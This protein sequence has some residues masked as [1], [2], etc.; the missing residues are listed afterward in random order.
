MS[1]LTKQVSDYR[2][3]NETQT[4][5]PKSYSLAL[6]QQQFP[7]KQQAILFSSTDGTK[8]EE[9]IFALGSLI[10]AK[11]ILFSSR[12]SNNRICIYLSS[13][14]AV[15]K[16][17]SEY[18]TITINEETLS[19]RR[20]ITP[21]ER[22]IL[23]NVCPTIPH[24]NIENELRKL[25]LNLVS[26][27]SFRKIGVTNPE[28]SH[29]LSFRR[30][31][32]ISPPTDMEI[33]ESL[34]IS[35]DDTSYR[36]FLSLDGLGC[37]KCKSHGHI[38]AHC[39]TN[40]TNS[41]QQNILSSQLI[42]SHQ[43]EMETPSIEPTLTKAATVTNDHQLEPIL[44]TLKRQFT[45]ILTP[46]EIPQNEKQYYFAKPADRSLKKSKQQNALD[47][48]ALAIS[49]TQLLSP[50]KKFIESQ[51][52]VLNFEQLSDFLFNTHGV[53]EPVDIALSYTPDLLGL[54]SMLEKVYPHLE[55]RGFKSKFTKVR[56]KLLNHLQIQTSEYD[57]DSSTDL[58]QV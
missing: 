31:I 12:I 16:F 14:N 4:T 47:K 38:A 7:S 22:L 30:Q 9:Y 41:S 56:R 37:F 19:A 57:S 6:T 44:P 46:P 58:S 50:A 11:N 3:R 2:N 24:Q 17:M 26:P 29:I 5:Q 45:E 52:F 8:L 13:K 1:N 25:G 51:K 23:S 55:A 34:L 40:N 18:G 32:Y 33:P 28:Y 48:S 35:Y 54:C 49:T 53:P 15:D 21:T 36:I 39:P 10:G 27:M 42:D 43:I 20:L